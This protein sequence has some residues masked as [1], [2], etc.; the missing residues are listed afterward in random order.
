MLVAT[1]E[2]PAVTNENAIPESAGRGRN[3][4]LKMIRPQ[5]LR[6]NL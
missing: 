6:L 5:T 3:P 1:G 4:W 2:V